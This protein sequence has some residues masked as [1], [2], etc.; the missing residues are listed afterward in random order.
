MDT[1]RESAIATK[2]AKEP[3]SYGS[4]HHHSKKKE[5]DAKPKSTPPQPDENHME[6]RIIG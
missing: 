1:L 4:H 3:H 6:M 5:E 2:N